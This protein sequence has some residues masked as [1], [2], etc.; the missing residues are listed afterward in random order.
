MAW[1]DKRVNILERKNYTEILGESIPLMKPMPTQLQE[2]R[3]ADLFTQNGHRSDG[4]TLLRSTGL[5]GN[6]T[7]RTKKRNALRTLSGQYL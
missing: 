3:S 6:T 2:K 4:G 7:T 1:S 5:A